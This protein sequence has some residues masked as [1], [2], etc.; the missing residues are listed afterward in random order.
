[1]LTFSAMVPVSFS[2]CTSDEQTSSETQIY[3]IMENCSYMSSSGMTASFA[4]ELQVRDFVLRRPIFLKS[5]SS[6]EPSS[7]L[8][9]LAP[10]HQSLICESTPNRCCRWKCK[11]YGM[12]SCLSQSN[13]LSPYQIAHLSQSVVFLPLGL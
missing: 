2:S 5:A 3:T 13:Y 6:A 11:C 1:M 10:Q 8:V 4:C 9:G 12:K 7:L